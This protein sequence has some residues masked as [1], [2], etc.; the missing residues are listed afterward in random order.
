MKLLD[1][2]VLMPVQDLLP[3]RP[4]GMPVDRAGAAGSDSAGT[5]KNR[6]R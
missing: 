2:N 6:S 4:A 3:I 5:A 1:T